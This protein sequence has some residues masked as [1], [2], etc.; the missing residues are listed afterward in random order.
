MKFVTVTVNGQTKTM[1]QNS[2]GS[3]VVTNTAPTIPGAYPVEL[4]LTTDSGNN[5]TITSD[6]PNLA[7]SLLLIVNGGNTVYG[8]QMLDYYPEIIK[9]IVEFQAL[10]WTEGFEFDVLHSEFDLKFNDAYLHLMNEERISE[11]EKVLNITPL[12]TD[13]LENRR[14]DIIAKFRG[15]NKLNTSAIANVV[16]VYTKGTASSRFEN[17]VLIVE[18][19]PPA[20]NK[21]FKFSAIENELK[22][23][24]PAHISLRVI[25][26]YATW[27]DV[28]SNFQS[29]DTVATLDDWISLKAYVSP[30]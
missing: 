22:R 20:H 5:V 16:D 25:R 14:D 3:W 6:D 8:Q 30:S 11:W 15:V 23:R 7:K 29:W 2:D 28:K 19:K 27:G 4:T 21:D 9:V 12:A 24:V 1:T 18:I 10:M 26:D 17:G 13:T